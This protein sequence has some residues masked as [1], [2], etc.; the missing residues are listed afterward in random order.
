MPFPQKKH[1]IKYPQNKNDLTVTV[2]Y[3]VSYKQDRL[4]WAGNRGEIIM[5]TRRETT[6]HLPPHGC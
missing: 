4:M 2:I 5:H 1:E 6:E 3:N